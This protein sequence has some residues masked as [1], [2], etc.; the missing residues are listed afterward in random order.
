M[1]MKWEKKIKS[2][3]DIVHLM[4]IEAPICAGY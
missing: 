1:N 4:S 3:T 2:E